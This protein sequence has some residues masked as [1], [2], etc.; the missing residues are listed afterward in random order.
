MADNV[1]INPGAG[2]TI[3]TD[4]VAGGHYQKVKIALGADGAVDGLV[5]AEAPLP[6]TVSGELLEALQALRSELQSLSRS[7]GQSYPDT[8]G[9]MRV[10]IDAI[11]ASLTLATITTV[12]TVTTVSTV[13]NQAQIGGI[14]ANQ[15]VPAMTQV[16]AESIR[17]N[18]SVT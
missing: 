8:A 18:I 16:A 11:T 14:S 9:R 4:E 7:I 5:S 6:T 3:A 1:A 2:A 17:R 15:M 12:T 10:A 13:T